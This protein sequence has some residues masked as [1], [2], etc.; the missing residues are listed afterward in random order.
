MASFYS[1]TT[2]VIVRELSTEP[3][4]GYEN[5]DNA[6][7]GWEY[8]IKRWGSPFDI[9]VPTMPRLLE[10]SFQ[11][12]KESEYFKSGVGDKELGDL[13]IKEIKEYNLLDTEIWLPV[14]KNGTYFRYKTKY[15]LFSDNS[16]V[17]Y[18]NRL[19]NREGRNYIELIEQPKMDSPF[20][21]ASFRR[22]SVTKNIKYKKEYNQVSSFSG[23]YVDGEELETVTS[24][25][26]IIWDNV[27]VNR[28][29]FII[30]KTINNT[31]RLFFSQDYSETVGFDVNNIQDLEVCE[32]I[33]YSTGDSFYPYKIGDLNISSQSYALNYFPVLSD[34]SF[35]LYVSNGSTYEEWTRVDT[36]WEMVSSTSSNFYWV[37]KDLGYVHF[38]SQNGNYLPPANSS[39]YASYSLTLRIEYEP[40]YSEETTTSILADVNPVTQN[41]NQGF[42]CLTHEDLTPASITL[43]INKPHI[44]GTYSPKQYGP[45]TTGS[46]YAVLKANVKSIS[47]INLPNIPVSFFL[48]PI[49][50]SLNNGSI[51]YGVTNSEGNSYTNYQPPVD[52]DSIGFYSNLARDCTNPS[53]SEYREIVI[54]ASEETILGMEESDLLTFMVLKD[55][56]LQGYKTVDDYLLSLYQIETPSWVVDSD[57]YV[58]WEE[59][60]KLKY[61]LKDFVEPAAIGEKIKGRKVVLYQI[62]GEDNFDSSAIHP[63]TG[64]EG[65]VSPVRPVLIEKIEGLGDGTDG[66]YRIVLASG[67][68]PDCGTG[69][70]VGGYWI[71]A[72]RNVEFQASCWS[73]Y[74]NKTIFSNK[75]NAQISLADY[76]KGVYISQLGEQ[77]PFGW[78]LPTNTDI[79]SSG[80]DGTTFI[81]INPVSGPYEILDL[82]NTGSTEEEW[83]SA[84]FKT[85]SF[86]FYIEE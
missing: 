75:I 14:I 29:E 61:D 13:K 57:T 76:L 21:A 30:D 7:S 4:V 11:G 18:I 42:V 64:E 83:A 86:Q 70:D 37:D 71:V 2:Q 8:D 39:I 33:G 85:I 6:P 16:S 27:D 80:I 77:I 12:V 46:D 68:V 65:A 40:E 31:T 55:D 60:T 1:K 41:I 51:A 43:S 54:S 26:K 66:L 20:L 32:K 69:E 38:A 10:P 67:A 47:S 9:K 15:F 48:N 19:D 44:T 82:V 17:E 5:V 28:K 63:I 23:L 56:I 24:A 81:T 49:I 73:P 59:E 35:H 52:A 72:D 53:Y 22:D 34:D 36:W 45:I 84:P 3:Y 74:Y 62:S 50:G 79:I 25:G 78:K 58:L